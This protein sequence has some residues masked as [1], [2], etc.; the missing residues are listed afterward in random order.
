[1]PGE[2]GDDGIDEAGKVEPARGDEP[3][4]SRLHG[5]KGGLGRGS[6]LI[7][8]TLAFPA[9]GAQ[10]SLHRFD[11]SSTLC[12]TWGPLECRREF[13]RRPGRAGKRRTRLAAPPRGIP[14]GTVQRSDPVQCLSHVRTNA[15][16]EVR[17]QRAFF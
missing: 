12:P 17:D 3:D 5:V 9:E 13:P 11:P 10:R 6:G 15:E 1:M 8:S 14:E 4:E 2:I 16:R 7:E